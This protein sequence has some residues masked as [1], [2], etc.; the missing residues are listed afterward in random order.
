MI[1]RSAA[2][3]LP[4][5]APVGLAA[6]ALAL[7]APRSARGQDPVKLDPVKIEAEAPAGDG[8]ETGASLGGLR[9]E[10]RTPSGG[11]ADTLTTDT[12]RLLTKVPGVSVSQAGAI[13][14]LPSIYGFADDRLRVQVDGVDLMPACPNHMNPPLSYIDPARVARVTVFRGIAPVSVG[15]DSLGGTI[16]VQP[17]DPSF[18]AGP[19]KYLAHATLGSSF[20]SNGAGITFSSGAAVAT[21]LLSVAFDQSI[22]RSGN[23]DAGGAFKLVAS[24]REGGPRLSGSE[25]GSSA[26]RGGPNRALTLATR[27]R[28]HLLQVNFSQQIVSFEGY[29][30]QRMDMTG[31]HNGVL[32]ARYVG[33]YSWGDLVARASYQHT[34]HQMDMGPDRYSYGTGMPMTSGAK[35]RA[36]SLQANILASARDTVRLGAEGLYY[37]L[38][39]WWPPVGGIMG[40]RTFWNV[41]FGE[42]LRGSGF[43]E[44]EAR[45]SPAWVTQIGVR[46]GAVRTN[47][48][49]VQGYDPG[50]R[51]AWGDDAARFNASKREQVDPHLDITALARYDWGPSG[52]IEIGY[53]RKTRSPNLYQRYTWSTNPMAALMNNTSGDGNGYVGNVGLKP[54]IANT[55]SVSAE[56]RGVPSKRWSA[57]A[58]A[59]VSYVQNYIDVRRC[60]FG[61]CSAANATASNAF[62]LLQ[63]VNH[64]A[65]LYGGDATATAVILK[66]QEGG[67]LAA[68]AVFSL[69]RGRNLTARDNLYAMMPPNVKLD[70]AYRWSGFE[71]IAEAVVVGDKSAVSR[72]RN[73]IP[74]SAYALLN[75]RTSYA[76]TFVRI[77][78][79]IENLLGQLYA[80]PLGGAYVGQGPSMSSATL[81]W[82]VAVPGRGRSL[83]L[84]MS[85]HL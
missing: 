85:F 77:D 22:A 7:M 23:Y 76:N 18:A 79:E 54:E 6:L 32:G 44:W 2:G 51:A 17:A 64:A 80:P 28:D 68:S 1:T 42:R 3:R 21:H 56:G 69:V 81:P 57:R 8:D 84:G 82:G 40:P 83:H 45:W 38:H 43:V 78:V 25:V 74:T 5:R 12:A 20:R 13:S 14:G 46:G 41:D 33:K 15:G 35:S 31:N 59:H 73:E 39:D 55:V 72:V 34:D 27:Y 60:D 65:V 50:L 19:G 26:Y 61:Q 10:A 70:L 36:A 52:G 48:G 30:N 49:P 67:E 63:Y 53:A 71:A 75:L 11:R 37:T 9:A 62:V 66:S 29:P 58:T 24:G 47:A 16:L 4:A